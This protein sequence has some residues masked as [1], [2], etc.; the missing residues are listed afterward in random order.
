MRLI[1][2]AALT[3]FLAQ[4]TA[5]AN[6]TALDAGRSYS[7]A[8]LAGHLDDVWARMTPEMREAF[9][10]FDG[11]V[12]FREDLNREFGAEVEVLSEEAREDA[13]TNVYLRTS[14]WSKSTT[15]VL[16]QWVL[17]SDQRIAGFLVKPAP[18]LAPSRF[19]DYQT[20]TPLNLPFD[21]EWYVVWGGRTLEQNYHA[22]NVAQRFAIDAVVVRDDS[23]HSGD[24]SDPSNYYCWGQVVRAPAPAKVVSVVRDLPDNPIG[25]TD[26]KNPAGNHVVLDFGQGEFGFLAHMQEGSITASEGTTVQGGQELGRCGNSG[27]TSEPHVHFHLQTTPDLATGEGLPAVFRDYLADGRPVVSGELKAGESI[28]SR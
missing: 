4:L 20:R 1:L 26:Q 15:P 25:T 22:A 17:I 10:G 9:G 5:L 27:N 6:D 11:M 23:T 28:R 3:F 13:G 16:M 14:R 21:G 19:L 7:Q 12:T 24:A 18:V 2:A 8:F